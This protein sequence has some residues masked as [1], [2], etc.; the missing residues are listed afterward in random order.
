MTQQHEHSLNFKGSY[1]THLPVQV[2]PNMRQ[3]QGLNDILEHTIAKEA[4]VGVGIG[5][6]L[7]GVAALV[8]AGLA[9]R[10]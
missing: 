9:S 7:V 10:R 8:I 4:L 2:A 5:A 6:G 1:L 3:A